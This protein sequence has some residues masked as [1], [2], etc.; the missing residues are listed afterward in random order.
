MAPYYF[1]D[2][3]QP[4]DIMTIEKKKNK[5]KNV[6]FVPIPI[7][8]TSCTYSP[9]F[10]SITGVPDELMQINRQIYRAGSS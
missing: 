1:Y 2:G 6:P 10:F 8:A 3:K 4:T 5:V 7:S 9:N